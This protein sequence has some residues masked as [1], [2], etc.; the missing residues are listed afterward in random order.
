MPIDKESPPEPEGSALTPITREG[1]IKKADELCPV[2]ETVLLFR[3]RLDGQGEYVVGELS[4]SEETMSANITD[5]AD[6]DLVETE[7]ILVHREPPD[8]ETPEGVTEK[9]GSKLLRLL[10]DD[11]LVVRPT[12]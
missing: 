11:R 6:E 10:D 4:N 9:L 7:R 1:L 5:N 8:D 2:S 3:L 12:D